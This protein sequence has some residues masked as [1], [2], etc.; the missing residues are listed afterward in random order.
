MPQSARKPLV[1]IVDDQPE[2][3][4]PLAQLLSDDAETLLATNW[5]QTLDRIANHPVDL[6]LLDV[7]LPLIDGFAICEQLKK[8]P[9]SGDIPVI[10]LTAQTDQEAEERGLSLGAIDYV[11]KPYRPE[12][13]LARV[14]NHLRMRQA[15]H[16]LN[17]EASTD[18]LTGLANRRG[19]DAWLDRECR[20]T[21]AAETL[22]LLLI[23]LDHFKHFNDQ[24]GHQS[25]DRIL[26]QVSELLASITRSEDFL[27]RWGG[28]EFVLWCRCPLGGAFELGERIRKAIAALATGHGPLTASIGVGERRR[29][30]ALMDL[31]ERVDCAL[32][33]AK[34]TGRDR[35]LAAASPR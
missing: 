13:M 25:G 11:H 33:N 16:A 14:R 27:G 35:V 19:I 21:P 18:R 1:L 4:W 3:L 29:G 12:L 30:E 22:S 7:G 9:R 34:R 23:D 5:Q 20:R 28:E 26:R 17:K 32:L 8:D 2:C 15:S 10:F 24:F 6:I 31:F